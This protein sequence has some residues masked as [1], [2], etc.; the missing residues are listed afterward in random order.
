MA[1]QFFR[2]FACALPQVEHEE[3][4]DGV[5][6]KGFVAVCV[7]FARRDFVQHRVDGV[8]GADD[9]YLQR[10]ALQFALAVMLL[11]PVKIDV[12]RKIDGQN[13]GE[14]GGNEDDDDESCEVVSLVFHVSEAI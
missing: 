14:E 12:G 3:R 8:K 4:Q 7:Q 11:W 10:P 5:R 2:Y 9:W 13:Q 6:S 1:V